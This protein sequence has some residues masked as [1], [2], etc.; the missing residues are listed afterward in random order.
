MLSP[1]ETYGRGIKIDPL[2]PKA[3]LLSGAE[4]G[5]GASLAAVAAVEEGRRGLSFTRLA[6]HLFL[7]VRISWVWLLTAG[8]LPKSLAGKLH[9]SV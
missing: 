2:C 7:L 1:K 9:F 4:G 6:A 8:C 5:A 3:A